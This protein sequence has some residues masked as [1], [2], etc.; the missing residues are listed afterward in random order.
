MDWTRPLLKEN[1]RREAGPC[2]RPSCTVAAAGA[3]GANAVTYRKF[4][5]AAE[6]VRYAVEELSGISARTSIMEVA[7]G[8]FN[9]MELRKLYDDNHYPLPRR[10]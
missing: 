4:D 6:A 8:R 3:G 7:E 2:R 9:H 1:T 5:S 10:T